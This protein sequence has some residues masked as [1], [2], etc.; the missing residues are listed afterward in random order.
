MSDVIDSSP[1]S[2]EEDLGACVARHCEGASWALFVPSLAHMNLGPELYAAGASKMGPEVWARWLNA[3][4]PSVQVSA[5]RLL[6]LMSL[7][8]WRVEVAPP[9]SLNSVTPER[10]RALISVQGHTWVASLAVV[11]QVH[12]IM[13]QAVP[14]VRA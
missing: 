3:A 4:R 9:S 13:L 8:R 14:A 1:L 11:P 7:H 5:Q 6:R 2:A 10:L 12:V